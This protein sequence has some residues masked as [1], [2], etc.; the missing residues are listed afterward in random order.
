MTSTNN[1]PITRIPDVTNN[2]RAITNAK[3]NDSCTSMAEY[4]PTYEE[5]CAAI[6]ARS[7]AQ[8]MREYPRL[9]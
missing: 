2:T 1:T 4:N 8:V 9:R 3:A 6:E 5:A 7:M